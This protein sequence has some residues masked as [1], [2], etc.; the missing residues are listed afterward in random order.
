MADDK[1]QEVKPRQVSI[2][3]GQVKILQEKPYVPHPIV[4]PR[5]H[6]LLIPC[7]EEASSKVASTS[8]QPDLSPN[9]LYIPKVK[10]FFQLEKCLEFL[11]LK[12]PLFWSGNLQIA[13]M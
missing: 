9:E 11:V 13:G 6:A 2:Q 7:L 8:S 4:H 3:N 12:F 1:K 10:P 5:R